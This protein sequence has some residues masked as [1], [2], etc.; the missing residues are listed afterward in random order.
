M[1]DEHDIFSE[2][3]AKKGKLAEVLSEDEMEGLQESLMDV[4]RKVKKNAKKL[5]TGN[6]PVK[7]TNLLS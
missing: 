4:L 2:L 3:M 1:R 6:P 5:N 7:I